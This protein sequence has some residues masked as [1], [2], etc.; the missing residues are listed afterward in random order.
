MYS[1]IVR[2]AETAIADGDLDVSGIP[3]D[4]NYESNIVKLYLSE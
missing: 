1:D 2:L 4:V 3:V